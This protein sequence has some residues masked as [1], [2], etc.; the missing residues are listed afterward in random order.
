[1]PPF[2]SRT[3]RMGLVWDVTP[4]AGK[5]VLTG[6]MLRRVNPVPAAFLSSISPLAE[7]VII[8]SPIHPIILGVAAKRFPVLIVPAMLKLPPVVK[9]KSGESPPLI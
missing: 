2:A 7:E 5:L 4:N 3:L 9:A 6:P 1:M 8:D